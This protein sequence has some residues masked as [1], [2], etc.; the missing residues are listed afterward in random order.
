MKKIKSALL[1]TII[2]SFIL[3]PV[4][5]QNTGSGAL[6]D[7]ERYAQVPVKPILITSEYTSMP[8]AHCLKQYGPIS[9]SQGNH[10]TCVGWASAFSARTILE[11]VAI[12]RTNSTQTSNNAFSPIHLYKSVSTDPDGA[13]GIYIEDAI[14]F[15]IHE[16]TVR[17]LPGE[18]NMEFKNIHLSLYTTSRRY[19]IENYRSVIITNNSAATINE[20][21]KS[22]SENKPVIFGMN[23]PPSFHNLYGKDLWEPT[24]NPAAWFSGHAMCITGYDNNKYGGAFEIQNSWGA[25]WG[26]GG[27]IWVRYND[28]IA[29]LRDAYEITEDMTNF[30][31][32]ASFGGSIEIQVDK[33]TAGMPVTFDQQGFYKTRTSYPSGTEFRFLL[34]NRHPSYVYAFSSDSS[35]SG[36]KRIFPQQGVSPILNYVNSTIAWPG[37]FQWI[38]LDDVVGTDHLVVLFSKQALD[39]DAIERR[40][41][42]ERGTFPQRV[43]RAVGS[44]FIP[45]N[46]AEYKN[47]TIE[48]SADSRNVSA[49]FG[50]LLAI[51]HH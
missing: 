42:T 8:G 17:R 7:P 12:K 18:R 22:I 33:S 35:N 20:I 6:F 25:D 39:I 45:F 49:V 41:A 48:F 47:D 44:N 40:F 34:T 28:F 37:E 29:W 30:T 38:K 21:K 50:L 14:L 31:N 3:L 23:T 5:A 32:A 2:F 16:G 26:I 9:E 19:L 36:I 46:Q 24:E 10:G 4:S 27:Y 15:M 1:F 11:S 51:D 43:S 13:R